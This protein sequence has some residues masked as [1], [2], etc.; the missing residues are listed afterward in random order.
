MLRQEPLPVDIVRMAVYE[1]PTGAE[2]YN[3]KALSIACA[4]YN[5]KKRRGMIWH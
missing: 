3:G 4:L 1:L 2:V 5:V